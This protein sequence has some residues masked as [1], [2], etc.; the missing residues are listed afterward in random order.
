MYIQGY[1]NVA[2]TIKS[3]SFHIFQKL[4]ERM[5]H[6]FLKAPTQVQQKILFLFKTTD[7][8]YLKMSAYSRWMTVSWNTKC[9]VFFYSDNFHSHFLKHLMKHEM[10]QSSLRLTNWFHAEIPNLTQTF[11][12]KKNEY[13]KVEEVVLNENLK[14]ISELS[15]CVLHLSH[16]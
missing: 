11:I 1:M 7:V 4:M 5:W 16:F 2:N 15:I 3:F 6:L 8:T 9:W 10:G 12:S 13:K 14:A